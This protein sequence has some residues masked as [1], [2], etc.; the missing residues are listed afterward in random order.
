MTEKK[1]QIYCDGACSGNQFNKNTGGWG[2]VLIYKEYTKSIF[3]GE[4]DTTNQRME[5]TACIKALESLKEDN[6]DVDVYSDSAYL[7]NCMNEKWYE[8]WIKN[9]WRNS[10]KKSVENQDLWMRLIELIGTYK[11]SFHKVNSHSGNENNE[12]AD[13]LAQRGIQKIQ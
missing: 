6:I 12:M 3:G 9:D 2:A 7:V 11:V 10:K 1:I 8:N 5:I 4:R 13:N